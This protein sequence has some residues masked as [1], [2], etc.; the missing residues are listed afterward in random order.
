MILLLIGFII[1]V[2]V[3]GMVAELGSKKTAPQE[4]MSRLTNT[5]SISEIR[6]P[7]IVAEFLDEVNVP[8][9]SQLVIHECKN[10]AALKDLQVRKNPTISANFIVGDDR[11]LILSGHVRNGELGIWTVDL[12]II[13]KLHSEFDRLWTAGK[14]LC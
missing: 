4:H 7:K 12:V 5:W 14:K 8:L 10:E 1:G 3:V 13:K 11:A 6:N 2:I 9:K